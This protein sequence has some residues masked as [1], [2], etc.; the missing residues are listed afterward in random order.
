MKTK[1]TKEMPDTESE[2]F[3]AFVANKPIN[4]EDY[5]KFMKDVLIKRINGM[6]MLDLESEYSDVI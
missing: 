3:I 2:A 4:H 6:N 5:K 1:T